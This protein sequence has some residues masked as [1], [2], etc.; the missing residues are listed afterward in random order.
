MRC[1]AS[2]SPGIEY[3]SASGLIIDPNAS[4]VEC[5]VATRVLCVKFNIYESDMQDCLS[6]VGCKCTKTLS[7]VLV[8]ANIT[9]RHG[10][11]IYV[12]SS[13]VHDTAKK[14]LRDIRGDNAMLETL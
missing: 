3:I 4:I 9:L 10:V 1:G 6:T 8:I 12:E 2:T 7:G 5:Y 14:N 11:K 13:T